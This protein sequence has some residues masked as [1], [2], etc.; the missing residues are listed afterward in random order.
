MLTVNRPSGA[1]HK[2]KLRPTVRPKLKFLRNTKDMVQLW[3][4]VEFEDKGTAIAPSNWLNETDNEKTCYWPPFDGQRLHKAVIDHIPPE[5]GWSIHRHIRVLASCVSY[6]KAKQCLKKSVQPDC[7]T[8][9]IQSDEEMAVRQKRRAKP[10][11]R[12]MGDSD[13]DYDKHAPKR[14]VP[15]PKVV[16]P[17]QGLAQPE[18]HNWYCTSQRPSN[19]WNTDR[20]QN[21]NHQ[22]GFDFEDIYTHTPSQQQVHDTPQSTS[23]KHHQPQY[24][25]LQKPS[26]YQG[27]N[28]A[29]F[30]GG[31]SEDPRKIMNDIALHK[32]LLALGQIKEEVLFLKQTTLQIKAQLKMLETE[33]AKGFKSEPN[34]PQTSLA[35]APPISLPLKNEMDLEETERILLADTERKKLITYYTMTGGHN[36]TSMERRI[37]VQTFTNEFASSLNWAGRGKKRGL[38]C[39]KLQDCIFYAVRKVFSSRTHAE[40]ADVVKRWLR[41]A[42]EREGGKQRKPSQP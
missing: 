24:H 30:S 1:K 4:V 12:Y 35:F 26:C 7:P 16:M 6:D 8:T 36:P 37:L 18:Q 40:F 33:V 14:R 15:Q 34:N 5:Q 27:S 9:D 22:R 25:T 38:Q 41:Y 2:V 20:W 29:E 17:V 13:D 3:K 39:T 11:P 23:P 42:P 21:E 31:H 28:L 10:N 32:V 19:D